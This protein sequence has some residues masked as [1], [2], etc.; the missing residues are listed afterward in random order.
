M[1]INYVYEKILLVLLFPC[2]IFCDYE[3]SLE[4]YNTTSPTYGSNVWEPAYLDYITM[5]YFST[6]G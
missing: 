5:H 3:Y 1:D 2:Y 6:Q 4:D